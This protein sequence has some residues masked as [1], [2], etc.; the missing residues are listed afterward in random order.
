MNWKEIDTNW[1][2]FVKI[3]NLTF[4]PSGSNYFYGKL[5]IYRAF[6]KFQ[7]FNIY[8]ENKF[9]K[10]AANTIANTGNRMTVISPINTDQNFRLTVTKESLWNKIFKSNQRLKIETS[11]T[12]IKN[13]L[14]LDEIQELITVFPD[15]VLSVRKYEKHQN[16][17]IAF[18]ETVLII[19]SKYQP[20]KIEHLQAYRKIMHSA[21]IGLEKYCQNS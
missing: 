21:L 2:A 7:K 19:N 1:K 12:S 6:E 13:S 18:D 8:Y 11:E 16:E 20:E 5:N 15:F 10:S 3:N 9:N 4:T 14:P 17:Q